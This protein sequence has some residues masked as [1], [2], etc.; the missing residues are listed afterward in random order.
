MYQ[1]NKQQLTNSL[2][3]NTKIDKETDNKHV[4]TSSTFSRLYKHVW[5][6]R[7]LKGSKISVYRARVLATFQYGSWVTYRHHLLLLRRFYRLCHP[8]PSLLWLRHEYWNPWTCEAH[9]RQ[10]HTTEVPATLGRTHLQEEES[11][12]AQDHTVK[13]TLHWS[14][15]RV[16]PKETI[17]GLLGLVWFGFFV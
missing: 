16:C 15:Y 5:H 17:H 8:Q 9:Q 3:K 12:P 1:N 11:S 14:L 6:K 7:Y 2:F 10:G 4:K 13:R